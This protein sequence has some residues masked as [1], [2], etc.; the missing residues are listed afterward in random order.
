M[1]PIKSENLK[2]SSEVHQCQNYVY[3]IRAIYWINS[4][5][6]EEQGIQILCLRVVGRETGTT[7]G[8]KQKKVSQGKREE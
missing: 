2:K 1:S 6:R 5:Q 8:R 3:D 7:N 4:E